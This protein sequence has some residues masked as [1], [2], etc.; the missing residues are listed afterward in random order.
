MLLLPS[1][2]CGRRKEDP[3]PNLLLITIDTLRADRLGCTDHAGAHTPVMDDLAK[4]GVLFDCCIVTTPITLPSHASIMTGLLPVEMSIRDNK[5]FSLSN[6]AQT[7]AEDLK[8]RGYV[9]HAVVSGEPLAPGCGLEQ[10]FDS[11]RF[12]PNARRSKA[13]LKEGPAD[14]TTDL[15]LDTVSRLDKAVPFFLWVHYFDP[16]F[17]YEPPEGSGSA[18]ADPYDGEVAF[19][20]RQIGRLLKGL[21]KGGELESTLIAL[22]SD[23]G[24][25][26]GEHGEPTHAFFLF[27]T[28]L[29][30]PLVIKG[31]GVRVKGR[32][33]VQI[34]SQDI[35]EALLLLLGDSE[36]TA[37]PDGSNLAT[38]IR[39]DGHVL[40]PSVAFSESLYCFRSFRWAQMTAFRT[41]KYKIIRGAEDTIFD[42]DSHPGEDHPWDS[43]GTA[44]DAHHLVK[45]MDSL[46]AAARSR[47]ER[48]PVFQADLPGYFGGTS[49]DAGIFLPEK[50]NRSLPHPPKRAEWLRAFLDAVACCA[51]GNV[52]RARSILEELVKEDP[53]NPSAHF[54]LGRAL[55]DMGEREGNPLII[56]NAQQRFGEA[57]RLEPE[58]GDAHHMSVWCLLQVGDF[59]EAEAA[60]EQWKAKKGGDSETW[61][62]FG[63]LYS[64][65]ASGGKKNDL[66]DFKKGLRFFD[67]SLEVRANNPRLLQTLI[68]MCKQRGDT[69]L[70]DKYTLKLETLKRE[71]WR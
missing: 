22:T 41:G 38:Y 64:H 62:L 57:L 5:P 68:Q 39:S 71:G 32:C 2:A 65:S 33:S 26:L 15:A 13:L 31:P 29:K 43:S 16:H 40:T 45:E 27:D 46:K 69:A 24:E 37:S 36:G 10:G 60:L 50:R 18:T 1:S 44:E 7:L 42:L 47:L 58:Y 19:V 61:E 14:R 4:Q 3:P 35:K 28:T 59:K 12:R 70:V 17:P 30:V 11:Y 49:G 55:R 6:E 8:A 20:D 9:T 52:N 23:H 48:G 54:W 66:Y 34:R 51:G 63:H 21:E 25:G 56:R 53:K 67:R